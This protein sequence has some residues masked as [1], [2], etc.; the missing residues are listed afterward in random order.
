MKKEENRKRKE[1]KRGKKKKNLI[2]KHI[3]QL[4]DE[5]RDKESLN[6]EE[7]LL[8]LFNSFDPRDI[9]TRK[10]FL[11]LRTRRG[12]EKTWVFFDFT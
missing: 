7:S 4:S 6:C 8:Y 1:E 11:P 2:L 12:L 9:Q 3:L 10:L 5:T